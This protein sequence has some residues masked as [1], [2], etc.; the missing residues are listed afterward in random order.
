MLSTLLLLLALGSGTLARVIPTNSSDYWMHD[1]DNPTKFRA[2]SGLAET[3]PEDWLN[4]AIR[5][6]H[7]QAESK[8]N[9]NQ[10]KNVILFMG[11]GMSVATL[12]ATR[13]YMGGEELKLSFEDFP[14][15]GMSKTYCV[16][17]Q[18]ADSACSSTAYLSGVKANYGT[19]GVTAAVPRGDCE[20]MNDPAHHTSSIAAWA[21]AAGKAAGLVTTT[22]VTHASPAGVYA[23]ISER[24]WENNDEVKDSECKQK[25]VDDVAKQMIFGDVGPKLKVV[26]GGGRR[27]FRDK[28]IVD[29]EG[30]KGKRSDKRD[31]IEEWKDLKLEDSD[32]KTYVWNKTELMSVDPNE[33]DYL[34]GLFEHSHC[35]YNLDIADE[36]IEDLEPTL[37]EMV[38]K[39]IDVLSKDP[40]GFF[41]FVEGGR[42]DHAH[43]DALVNYALDETAE[44]A[45]AIALA[46]QM[47]N[48]QDTLIVT[49]ADHAHTMTYAGYS[50]RIKFKLLYLQVF[51]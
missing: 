37:S 48:G 21:I 35:R 29:E 40:N 50:V 11:D 14:H 30:K 45:K 17:Y 16:D 10:A 23:H 25:Y 33:V 22:R 44:F 26:M 36:G 1:A 2:V 8:V 6:V 4:D 7:R 39:A 13:V 51:I 49:T 31:L 24:G 3:S 28:N 47:M 27:E 19:L 43:H 9:K 42:I 18:V 32:R 12:A 5:F 46:K 15:T 38:G 41:L 20:L 34:L